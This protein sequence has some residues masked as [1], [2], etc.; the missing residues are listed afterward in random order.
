MRGHGLG[1]TD[2][3]R[4]YSYTR[5]SSKTEPKKKAKQSKPK[6]NNNVKHAKMSAE[7]TARVQRQQQA[8]KTEMDYEIE[9][10][11]AELQQERQMK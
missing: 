8:P 5:N 11:K 6:P 7:V 10:L 9:R 2:I 3:T 4:F 1:S